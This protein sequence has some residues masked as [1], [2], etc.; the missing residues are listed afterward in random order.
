MSDRV[1]NYLRAYR[2]RAGL[3][4]D[5]MA[6]LLGGKDGTIVSRYECLER[7]PSLETV[8]A[9]EVV[10]GVQARDLVAGLYRQ[11]EADTKPRVQLLLHRV[12][13]LDP[14]PLTARKLQILQQDACSGGLSEPAQ[15][16]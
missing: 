6:F 10:F 8:F 14:D 16:A 4:Q 1:H 9:Y 2:K 12:G 13:Q 5:E 11:V 7:R 3:S 15:E